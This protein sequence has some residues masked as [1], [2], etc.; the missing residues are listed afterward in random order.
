MTEKAR[1]AHWK[2]EPTTPNTRGS[3][4]NRTATPPH[5]HHATPALAHPTPPYWGRSWVF[6]ARHTARAPCCVAGGLVLVRMAFR[7]LHLSS[8]IKGGA[9]CLLNAGMP[10]LLAGVLVWLC[11]FEVFEVSLLVLF[12][13]TRVL[14]AFL[15]LHI[16]LYAGNREHTST[17]FRPRRAYLIQASPNMHGRP[18]PQVH[19]CSPSV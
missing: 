16:F 10:A 3:K 14:I 1:T 12:W 15:F 11:Y 18:W 5:K 19:S 9:G 4:E 6:C 17:P 13:M 2:W 7:L 8:D